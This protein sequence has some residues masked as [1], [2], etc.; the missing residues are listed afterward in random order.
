MKD[1]KKSWPILAGCGC[2]TLLALVVVAFLLAGSLKFKLGEKEY[3]FGT[4][5]EETSV[6]VKDEIT[7]AAEKEPQKPLKK[8]VAKSKLN[9]EP[10]TFGG[11]GGKPTFTIKYPVGW[12]EPNEKASYDFIRLALVPEQAEN[13]QT[14]RANVFALIREHPMK[15]SS[16]DDY[17]EFYKELI[18]QEIPSIV[19]LDEMLTTLGGM[20]ALLYETTQD[21]NGILIHQYHYL[22]YVNDSYVLMVTGNSLASSWSKNK[23]VLKQSVDSVKLVE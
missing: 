8:E 6:E 19:F 12:A 11:D 14:Y 16:I 17:R 7:P 9:S 20:D 22:V 1:L 18:K 3:K 21:A 23:D 2:L 13:N 4:P 5:K 10:A 15:L